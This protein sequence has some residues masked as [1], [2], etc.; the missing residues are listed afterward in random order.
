MFY[1]VRLYKDSSETTIIDIGLTP[2]ARY[3]SNCSLKTLTQKRL[4]V[5]KMA[6]SQDREAEQPSDS[7]KVTQVVRVVPAFEPDS[8]APGALLCAASLCLMLSPVPV[9]SP[10]LC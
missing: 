4:S 2:Y 7:P 3:C 1:Y 9:I 5:F 10:F 6:L 8:V